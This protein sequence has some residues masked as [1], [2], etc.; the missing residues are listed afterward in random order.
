MP[1]PPRCMGIFLSGVVE[2]PPDA[3][4]ASDYAVDELPALV[5]IGEELLARLPSRTDAAQVGRCLVPPIA[6]RPGLAV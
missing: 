1:L 5:H 4:F 3:D 2:T 6:S